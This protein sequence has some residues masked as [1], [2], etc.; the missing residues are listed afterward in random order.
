MGGGGGECDRNSISVTFSLGFAR[1][2]TLRVSSRLPRYLLVPGNDILVAF[3]GPL[4]SLICDEFTSLLLSLQMQFNQT[5]APDEASVQVNKPMEH[6]NFNQVLLEN[7]SAIP[8][9]SAAWET[10]LQI[11]SVK[12]FQQETEH[13]IA[14][15]NLHSKGRRSTRMPLTDRRE[16]N[17]E[18]ERKRQTRLKGAFNVLR[19]VI[20]DYFSKREPGDRLSRIQTLRL[21]KKYIAT[22]HELLETD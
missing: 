13:T 5:N 17:R 4:S 22:L 1:R 7:S 16:K 12:K 3:N 10:L 20:P 8:D 15:N 19:S 21:A 2:Y 11:E 14:M 6:I 18:R 9:C